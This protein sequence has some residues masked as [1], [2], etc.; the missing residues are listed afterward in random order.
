MRLPRRSRS[1][2]A[3]RVLFSLS[4]LGGAACG[5]PEPTATSTGSPQLAHVPDL[6]GLPDLIVD[7]ATLATSWVIYE[8][9]LS[10][11]AC[12]VIEGDVTPGPHRTLRI[13]VNTPN[14]GDADLFVGDPNAHWDP[15]GDGSG[16]DS[17]G[18]FEL[19]SCHRHFHFRNYATYELFPVNA[20]GSLGDVVESAKR[21]F[22]MIDVAPY[23][24]PGLP[25]KAWVYRSCGAIG[26]RGNQGI[27]TGWADQYF[28]WL[29]GQYF[30]IDGLPAGKYMIRIHVNP[31]F[32][33]AGGEPCP[34]VDG[35]GFCHQLPESDFTNNVAEIFLQIPAGR[36]GK[37]GFGP[38][39][40][41]EL[42]PN[43]DA[44][45]DDEKRV[46]K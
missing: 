25:P 14:I 39:G 10:A 26:R 21:G 4:S 41:Q 3:W 35:D 38:G 37:T 30:V 6:T 9:F 8:E 22:C 18:L 17:D 29:Q 1:A 43:K 28:K 46:T 12:D 5:A 44:L 42:P 11:T 45:I 40:G 31:P 15:N 34:H 33:P 23:Q 20:D 13:T 2:L 27:A 32:T 19:A 7:R 36:P 24:V 16:A